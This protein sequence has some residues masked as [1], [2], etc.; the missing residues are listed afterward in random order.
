[1]TNEIKL[2]DITDLAIQEL[3]ERYDGLIIQGIDDKEGYKAVKAARIVMKGYRV[4]IDK[5]RKELTADALKHQRKIN[6]E[7]KRITEKLSEIEDYL[8]AEQ[9]KIDDAIEMIKA[10]EFRQIELKKQTR[11]DSLVNAGLRFN[12]IV[13][14]SVNSS[15]SIT[16]AKVLSLAE[17]EFDK[18]VYAE[19]LEKA[20]CERK[21]LEIQAEQQRKAAAVQA[22]AEKVAAAHKAELDKIKEEQDRLAAELA[23]ERAEAQAVLREL[24]QQQEEQE[25]AES[26][27]VIQTTEPEW[28]DDMRKDAVDLKPFSVLLT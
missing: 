27:P 11:I 15:N 6:S 24:L 20:E 23:V 17:E 4:D 9:N 18:F 2:F 21:R 26:K 14:S 22:E 1:M 7:A 16:L 3:K 28:V 10:E 13:F 5:R 19:L 12:G 8:I 25:K